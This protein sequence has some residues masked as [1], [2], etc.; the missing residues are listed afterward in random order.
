MKI[1]EQTHKIL[2]PI[3]GA[4]ILKHIERIGRVAYKSEDKITDDSAARFVKML[5]ERGH[6]SVLEHFS[7]SVLF[8]TDRGIS[9]EIVRH[10][11]ASY[12]QEST[13]Y[14]NYNGAKF[15]GE[16][17]VIKP[18][19]LSGKMEL[20][21]W[22]ALCKRCESVYK[23]LCDVDVA[24]QIARS[25]LPNCLKTEIVMTANLREWRHFRKLRTAPDAHPQMRALVNPL[26][27]ELKSAI[28]I[29][30]DDI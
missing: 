10:R 1:I 18:T 11:L 2:T 9:H 23:F 13:R 5:I 19:N 16:I 8:V 30:F 6:E 14:C 28:P 22:K 3:N 17:T 26:L 27:N 21:E 29:V 20:D 24:P 15:N 7:F 25:V 12:T 4:E